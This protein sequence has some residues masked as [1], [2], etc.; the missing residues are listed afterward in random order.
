M[1]I[2]DTCQPCFRPRRQVT[3]LQVLGMRH[4]VRLRMPPFNNT[5]H[6]SKATHAS[7]A[8]A[9]SRSVR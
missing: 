6:A 4:F 7:A 9:C 5:G 1:I 2:D 3:I 8:S